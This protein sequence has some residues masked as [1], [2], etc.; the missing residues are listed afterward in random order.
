MPT[1]IGASENQFLDFEQAI[2]DLETKIEELPSSRTILPS[3]S[4]EIGRLEKKS[5]QLCKEHLRQAH[6]WQV[7][8]VA[9]HPQR[10]AGLDYISR[11]FTVSKNSTATAPFADDHA[12]VG[13]LAR[14]NGQPVVVIGREGPRH[15]RKDFPQLR[16]A[17]S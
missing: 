6:P 12:I 8:Q 17:A 13:G 2:A 9:R 15:Q 4:Q 16:H 5:A 10:P 7:A 3:I 11:I 1:Q 14:F